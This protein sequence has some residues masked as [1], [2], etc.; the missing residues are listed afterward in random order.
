M[1]DIMWY[2]AFMQTKEYFSEYHKKN[3]FDRNVKS[4]EYYEL[5]RL[6]VAERIK[7]KRDNKRKEVIEHLGGAC[8]RCGYKDIRALQ[9]DHINGGGIKDR[10][11]SIYAFLN[12]VL[13]DVSG[14]YQLLCANCNQIKRIE[15]REH[16][17]T[18]YNRIKTHCPKGHEYSQENTHFTPDGRRKCLECGRIYMRMKRANCV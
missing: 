10:G 5:N 7:T 9:I 11:T 12:K 8:V 17:P 15:N 2:N 16:N 13:N 3:R 18:Y 6:K 1:G 4:A 14:L